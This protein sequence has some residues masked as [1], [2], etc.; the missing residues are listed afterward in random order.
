M[1]TQRKNLRDWFPTLRAELVGSIL[2]GKQGGFSETTY[3]HWRLPNVWVP[4]VQRTEQISGD[5]LEIDV[6]VP[7]KKL[8]ST[9]LVCVFVCGRDE[10]STWHQQTLVCCVQ[11]LS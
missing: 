1:L 11:R 6:R 7:L 3:I 10:N 2:T 5:E 4:A 9:S 8:E